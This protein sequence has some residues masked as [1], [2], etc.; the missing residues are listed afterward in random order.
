V[1]PQ[2]TLSGK[3]GRERGT[4]VRTTLWWSLFNPDSRARLRLFCFPYAGGHASIYKSWGGNVHPLVEVYGVQLPGRASRRDEPAAVD[5][6]HLAGAVASA[7]TPLLDRP[8]AFFGHSLGAILAFEVARWIRRHLRLEPCHFIA[9]AHQ[10]PQSPWLH[11]DRWKASDEE[12]VE[13]IRTL[14]GTPAEIMQ[15]PALLKFLLPTLRADFQL[16]DT[17]RYVNEPALTCPITALGARHDAEGGEV[18]RWGEQ[19]TGPFSTRIFSGDHFFIHAQE[20]ELL[21]LVGALLD[22]AIESLPADTAVPG[23]LDITGPKPDTRAPRTGGSGS[24]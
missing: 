8:F 7:L 15:N 14:N 16:S 1:E 5:L 20:A 17:Y 10:A 12:F 3:R 4:P 22:R 23:N 2:V 21:A 18:E 24:R 13:T 11:T 6:L 19:T 9:S